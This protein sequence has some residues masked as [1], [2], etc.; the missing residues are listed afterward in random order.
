MRK[1]IIDA[2]TGVDDSVALLYAL[3][4]PN[5]QVLGITTGFGNTTAQNAALNSLRMV[6]LARPGYE[7]PVALGAECALNGVISPHPTGIHGENGLANVELPLPSAKPID[8]P[9]A[10]FIV[11]MARQ[12]PGEITLVTLGRMTNLA[13]AL[14][15]E[16]LLPRL[17][18]QVV[19]MGGTLH[20]AGNVAPGVEANIGGDPEAADRVFAAGFSLRMVGLDVTMATRLQL[21]QIDWLARHSPS[22]PQLEMGKYLCE[23]LHFY[24]EYHRKNYHF[25]EEIPLHD[26]LAMLV[27]LHPSLGQY[28]CWPARV[29]LSGQYT[30]GMIVADRRMAPME[31]CPVE[32]CVQVDASA[33]I[34]RLLSAFTA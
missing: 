18:R 15:K 14:E 24:A 8:R 22:S 17:L 9:S 7:V 10:H 19:A 33:A 29:E 11:E 21:R 20:A 23:A 6:E 28:Q 2:D 27:A 34:S 13:L 25:V 30:R 12:Y 16:P 26:P 3:R 31:A 32:F 4:Q 1:I 5:V